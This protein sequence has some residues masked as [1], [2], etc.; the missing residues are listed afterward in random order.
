MPRPKNRAYAEAF[1][2][3]RNSLPGGQFRIFKPYILFVV[4]AI[5]NEIKKDDNYDPFT[6]TQLSS[7][8]DI[9]DDV[10]TS[11]HAFHFD[12]RT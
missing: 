10:S 8:E 9:N 11:S 4:D 1:K 6:Y 5:K 2:G 12:A 3:A 7:M